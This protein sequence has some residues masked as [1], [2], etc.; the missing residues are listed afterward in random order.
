VRGLIRSPLT[1]PKGNIEFLT[2]LEY[3]G[4]QAASLE[5]MVDSVVPVQSE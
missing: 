5:A 3:P 1:G 2:W 4:E